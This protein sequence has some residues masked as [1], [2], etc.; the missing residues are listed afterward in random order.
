MLGGIL[1][2]RATTSIG[3]LRMA[4]SKVGMTRTRSSPS[5]AAKE[6]QSQRLD[7]RARGRS[8]GQQNM[9]GKKETKA[10]GN[11]VCFS[12][13]RLLVAFFCSCCDNQQQNMVLRRASRQRRR[14]Y[15]N[16]SVDT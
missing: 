12:H 13:I 6:L 3:A 11:M 14:T 15:I 9:R 7:S 1:S 16:N 2:I 10:C 4:L 5:L 8:G